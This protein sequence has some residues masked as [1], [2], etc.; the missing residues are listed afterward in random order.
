MSI[1]HLFLIVEQYQSGSFLPIIFWGYG[2]GGLGQARSV[3][4]KAGWGGGRSTAEWCR[5]VARPQVGLP[6]PCRATSPPCGL[7]VGSRPTTI[8]KATDGTL[9]GGN[10]IT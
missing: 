6:V 3:T 7:G 10:L 9:W 4:N 2:P 1:C 5:Q 8:L